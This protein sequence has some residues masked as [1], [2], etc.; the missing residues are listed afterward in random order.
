MTKPSEI[1]FDGSLK[2]CMD[3]ADLTRDLCHD[4]LTMIENQNGLESSNEALVQQC[5]KQKQLNA[6]LAKLKDLHRLTIMAGREAKDATSEARREV[7]RLHLQLQNLYYEQRHLR[8]EV[9]ACKEFPHK[10]TSLPLVSEVEF[11]ATHPEYS[12]Y[13]SHTLMIARLD[14]EK[15][16]RE[17][18]EKRRK[19]LMIKK[20]ALIAEN[21]RRKDDLTSLDDQLK[22]FIESSRP[23]QTT[24]QKEY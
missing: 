2:Q 6:M 15:M 4:I 1:S 8:G 18:L 7:D 12:D 10:Y 14:N 24:F 16:V 11:K 3:A 22:K 19:D 9:T 21:K 5:R 13:D 20:Q 17:E 23:I